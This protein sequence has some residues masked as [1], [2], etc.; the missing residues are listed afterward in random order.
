[1]AYS[2][3][4]RPR[5]P[6]SFNTK[7]KKDK[8]SL[9]KACDPLPDYTGKSLLIPNQVV[10]VTGASR[11]I[12][13]A[14]A[15]A[16]SRRSAKL[17]LTS[18]SAFVYPGALVTT[19]DITRPEDRARIVAATLERFGRIDI[20]INNAGQGAYESAATMDLTQ[21][22]ALFELN[23]F[24]PL[25]MTQLV[26]PQM[27]KQGSG[28]IVNVGSIAGQIALPWMTIYSSTKFAL[29]GMTE[30]LR[31]E[32]RST[33]IHMMSVCPGYVV[34]PFHG[35]A[36]GTPPSRIAGAKRFA[37]TAERCAEAVARGVE[38]EA[39]TVVTPGIGWLLVWLNRF[40]PSLVESRL[41]GISQ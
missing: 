27:R 5:S 31:G 15:D 3:P 6:T 9:R 7:K 2:K 34:T 40:L 38:R 23:F 39:R 17:S 36:I 4:L 35:H 10:L 19:G 32:L 33:G 24:A 1:M 26:L 21:A 20:L 37:I 41:S 12:G 28:T 22:R 14:C 30:A 18:R 11:G 13:S 29:G 8:H 25:A 16:F